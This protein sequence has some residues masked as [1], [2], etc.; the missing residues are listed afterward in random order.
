MVGTLS[1]DF[2][3]WGTW[4][5][6]TELQLQVLWRLFPDEITSKAPRLGKVGALT[7]LQNRLIS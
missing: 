2:E 6:G 4:P 1:S 5:A 3:L 7:V